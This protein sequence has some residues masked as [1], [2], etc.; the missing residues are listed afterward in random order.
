VEWFVRVGQAAALAGRTIAHL[1]GTLV[2]PG[3]WGAHLYRALVGALPVALVAGTALGLVAWLQLRNLLA[4]FQSVELLPSALALAVV[5]EFGPVAAGLIAA[6]RLGAGLGAELGAM[7]ISE[8]LDAAATLGVP[9][10]PR[11]IAPRVL[12]CV[13][14]LPLVTIFVDYVAVLASYAAEAAGGTMTWTE[15]RRACL[16]F[17]KL[18]DVIPATLKTLVFGF[19]VGFYGCLCGLNAEG[20]TE[21]VGTA[22]TRAVVSAT[23]AVLLADV[24]LVR[25]IQL[26]TPP[27]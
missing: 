10:V 23:L 4:Q 17:L 19:L 12:A 25:L 11:V 3:L 21:G 24:V 9:I 8:Q 26:L 7:R 16:E 2:R 20:G 22:A 27:G 1:P 15:Y 18:R 6:G 13:L 5:W 14:A